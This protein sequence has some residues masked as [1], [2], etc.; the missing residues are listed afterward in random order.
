MAKIL[1]VD[2]DADV[3]AVIEIALDGHECVMAEDGIEALDIL[4]R[5]GFDAVVLDVMMPRMDGIDTLRTIRRDSDLKDL[6]VLMLTAKVGEDDHLRGFRS[7]AD[8]YLTK[9]FDPD[10]LAAAVDELRTMPADEREKIRDEEKAKAL[11]L[12]QIERRFENTGA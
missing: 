9:P 1:I 5:G 11:L 8:A 7:G 10:V 4:A 2:D 12:R 6:P 3:R